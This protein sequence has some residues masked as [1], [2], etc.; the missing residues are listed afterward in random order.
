MSSLRET[1]ITSVS[2]TIQAVDKAQQVTGTRNDI[3]KTATSGG[4][5]IPSIPVTAPSN[6]S[7]SGKG[8]RL[9]ISG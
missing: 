1:Y 9:N 2:L 5:A 3:Q 6:V 7:E 8:A 4:G